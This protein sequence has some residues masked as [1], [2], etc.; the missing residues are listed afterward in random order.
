MGRR[1]TS[2]GSQNASVAAATDTIL[3][4]TSATTIRP[5]IYGIL[6]GSAGVPADNGL[7][8]DVQRVTATGAD[9][10]VTP[11]AHDPADPA[12]LATAGSNN[13]GAH[14]YTAGAILDQ[15]SMNQKSTFTWETDPELGFIL[16]AT[17]DSGIGLR[18]GL[19]SAGT[20]LVEG[21]Y[22]HS[23]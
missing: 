23:E 8:I 3:V 14:T 17:A 13:T 22:K 9:T 21:R 2:I 12:S 20:I 11:Q 7:R 19:V 4:L 18:F 1:Y 15:I 16:P 6:I 10:A 5:S